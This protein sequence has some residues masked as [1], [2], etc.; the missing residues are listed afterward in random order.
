MFVSVALL[1]KQRRE[2]D[3]AEAAWLNNVAEYDRSND[4]QL[5]NFFSAASALRHT[6]NID[7]GIAR[8]YVDLARKLEHLPTV[9]TAFEHGQISQRHAQVIANAHTPGRAQH[10]A[11]CEDELVAVARDH[12]PKTLRGI[13]RHLT[14][15]IDGDGGAT[16]DATAFEQRAAYAAFTLDGRH[17]L[18][19]TGDRLS[20]ELIETALKAEMARDLQKHDPRT[21]PQR[22]YDA[23]VN[24]VRRNL[25]RGDLGASHGI[26]PHLNAVFNID[27]RPTASTETL[28]KVRTEPGRHNLSATMLG[29]LLCDCTLSRIIMH[30]RSEVLDVG[31][32][33][34]T[35]SAAQWKAL[36]ARDRHC[37]ASQCTRPPTDCHAHHIIH[38]EHGG[39]T[40]LANLQLLC[41]NHHRQTHIDDAKAQ[42]RGG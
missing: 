2:I 11:H 32:A 24:L 37:T 34:H 31:R 10:L 20:G 1:A 40:N 38:W 5:D 23:F 33:T 30:G 22:R 28:V 8:G 42:A 4:W 17:D 3:A 35:V 15:A 6:C 27:E 25:D 21:T 12:T 13:V 18:Q 14:D 7:E 26:R 19:L 39:L 41:W 29:M 16:S 36:V 9:A